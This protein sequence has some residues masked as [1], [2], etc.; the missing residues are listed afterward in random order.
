[1]FSF[2][3]VGYELLLLFIHSPLNVAY[4]QTKNLTKHWFDYILRYCRTPVYSAL[5]LCTNHR[6]LKLFG[7]GMPLYPRVS[8]GQTNPWTIS[9]RPSDLELSNKTRTSISS[10]AYNQ[11]KHDDITVGK[12]PIDLKKL[13]YSLQN[14]PNE[15]VAKL[16]YIYMI[17]FLMSLDN[18]LMDLS[19]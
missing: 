12:S 14:Y 6:Y 9:G 18:A 7:H 15:Q 2:A 17:Y 11:Y 5:C 16:Q 1:M 19:F 10:K 8:L 13:G 4:E 3:K